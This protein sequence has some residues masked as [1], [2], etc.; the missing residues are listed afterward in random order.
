MATEFESLA[1]KFA[2]T[3]YYEKTR[4][5]FEDISPKS[6]RG[7][8]W[9]PV[10]NPDQEAEVCIQYIAFFDFQRWAPSI[11]D[12]VYKFDELS[13]KA[14]GEHP[15]DYVPIFLYFKNEKPVK[16]VFDICHYEAV[17]EIDASSALLPQEKG[18]I[19][20]IR[21]FYRG[22]LPLEDTRGKKIL[23]GVPSFLSQEDLI[24]W[25]NGRT[26][27]GSYDDKAKLIIKEKLE[28]PFQEITTFKDH[29]GL[30]G[31]VFDAIFQTAK[32][33]QLV[34]GYRVRG[35]WRY[36]ITSDLSE[37]KN[38][39]GDEAQ[40]FSDDDIKDIFTESGVAEYLLFHEEFQKN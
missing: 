9:R 23:R 26:S 10:E 2:P 18:P 14:P 34:E 5:P 25:W 22:L 1:I 32:E 24:Q 15:N 12:K 31:R 17:G 3:L 6:S 40:Y 19:L 33:F 8:Y 37:V 13:G 21:N 11:F 4:N 20:Y 27:T 38:Q 36:E 16:A 39:L 29:S 28:N 30:F 35:G 7:L